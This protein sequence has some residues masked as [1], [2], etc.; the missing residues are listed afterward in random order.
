MAAD[1]YEIDV[2][3]EIMLMEQV[4]GP[5][6]D[7]ELRVPRFQ[8]PF[9]WRPE[10]IL[11]LFDSIERGYPIGSLLF[12]ETSD[13]LASLDHIGDLP[14]PEPRP[15]RPVSYVL[16]G[17]QRLSTLYAT[18][19]RPADA[20]RSTE[21]SDWMWWPYRVLGDVEDGP[22]RY[23]HWKQAEPPPANYLPLRAVLRTRDFLAY[24]R[25]LAK[26]ATP[27]MDVDRLT[28][29]AEVVAQRIRSYKIA[30]VRLVDGSLSDAVEV[31]SR[32]NSTGQAM[33]PAEM[34]SALTYQTSGQPTLA[35][36]L[37]AMVEQI[38][39]TGFGEISSDA[40]FRAV[41][42][43]T[44]EDNVQEGR[45]DVLAKR[46]RTKLQEAAD[47]T[48]EALAHAVIFLRDTVGVPL[49]RLIPY[50]AQLM[51]LTTFFHHCP[52]PNARQVDELKRWFWVTSWSGHFAGAN[53]T[54]IK[55]SIQE[56]RR[57]ARDSGTV[58]PEAVRA[59]PF[60]SRFDMRSARVR[61]F[62]I[63]ELQ[64]F[65]DR[66]DGDGNKIRPVDILA[67]GATSAYRHIIIKPGLPAASSPANRLIMPTAPRTSVRST[68]LDLPGS[69][70]REHVLTSHG[71][72]DKAMRRLAAGDD[73]RF[74]EIRQSVLA[75]RERAFMS[76]FG[77][78]T[79]SGVG[80]ADI[81]TS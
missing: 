59:R 43:V 81:D 67:R 62:I 34:V 42:A 63:W 37:D 76:S 20:K 32:V 41:L 47:D 40:I 35:D 24:A 4:L 18:L 8:R 13:R 46:V 22:N 71:I 55:Q 19:R 26:R 52:S 12:W 38:A 17:H 44:G 51:L 69:A 72:P 77:L 68:L 39:D 3:P 28:N 15:A 27:D 54:Q 57:F 56:M 23:R 66:L 7:G 31:F 25:D 48:E 74:I 70:F 64:E 80:E 50:D 9:V 65:P 78:S 73:E 75:E 79:D 30:V 2:K 29:E 6:A 60:P 11:N 21:Q 16:D 58:T 33:R 14:V 61:A 36:R 53:T 10:Q 45:W 1:E 49:A 5:L